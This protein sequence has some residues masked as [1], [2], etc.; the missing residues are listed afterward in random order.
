MSLQQTS[1]AALLPS[2]IVAEIALI[3]VIDDTAPRT[4]LPLPVY[5]NT[6]WEDLDAWPAETLQS[7]CPLPSDC[8]FSGFIERAVECSMDSE[9]AQTI[10][11]PPSPPP[12]G[13]YHSAFICARV[14][15]SWRTAVIN[16]RAIWARGGLLNLGFV[17]RSRK[18]AGKFATRLVHPRPLCPCFLPHC[19]PLLGLASDIS[20][21]TYGR[22]SPNARLQA[23]ITV[24]EVILSELEAA[25]VT[26]DGCPIQSLDVQLL[27]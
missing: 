26:A 24:A 17:S 22:P 10:P 5:R 20:F 19:I 1:L 4:W 7:C 8:I 2:E 6:I 12:D 25:C 9:P 21:T 18:L 11:A 13:Y 27:R 16:H 23:G 14:C 3:T 15:R